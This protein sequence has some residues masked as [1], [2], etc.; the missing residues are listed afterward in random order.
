LGASGSAAAAPDKRE[1]FSTM[2]A[3]STQPATTWVHT[4][5]QRA[6][7]GYQDPTLGWVSVRADASS[8]G[9]HAQLVP[10]SADAAQA[11]GGQLAGLNSY[12]AEHHAS[13]DTLTLSSPE[14]GWAGMNS[15]QSSGGGMQQGGEQTAQGGDT[16]SSTVATQ[17][18]QPTTVAEPLPVSSVWTGGSATTQA[19]GHISVVA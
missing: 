3:G 12:L 6:E 16:N 8:G 13:V 17:S 15:G 7:A 11:L 10:E 14:G 5:A 18:A 9:V 2:D 4:G 19:G 1:S